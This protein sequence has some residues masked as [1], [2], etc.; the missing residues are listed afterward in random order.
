MKLKKIASLALAGI[1]AVSMLAGCKDGSDNNGGT[2]NGG[3]ITPTSTYTSTVLSATSNAQKLMSAA[4]NS[5]LDKA[6]SEVAA[7]YS[8]SGTHAALTFIRED[9]GTNSDWV[10]TASRYMGDA[11][12]ATNDFTSHSYVAGGTTAPLKNGTDDVTYYG[13]YVV[14]RAY[15]DEMIDNLVSELLDTVAAQQ[16]GDLKDASGN[17][18]DYSVSVAKA[19]CWADKKEADAGADSVVVGIAVTLDYTKAEF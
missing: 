16:I 19:D 2:G 13:F 6:V 9:I 11:V 17:T 3:D 4:P 12:Y 10:D 18:R 15:N 1:M 7:N 8:V 5:K 14:K